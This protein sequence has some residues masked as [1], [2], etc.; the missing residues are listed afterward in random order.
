M[1]TEKQIVKE[2]KRILD[3]SLESDW[4]FKEYKNTT[5][6]D[7]DNWEIIRRIDPKIYIS[8]TDYYE[9]FNINTRIEI[10]LDSTKIRLNLINRL[11]LFK[12]INRIKKF[13]KN[14]AKKALKEQSEKYKINREKQLK[15]F[16]EE[17]S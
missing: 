10:G 7:S 11:Y 13:H 12:S 15:K 6:R 5:Y 14:L 9:G 3:E 1:N 4:H 17:I 16:L 8:K 2:F